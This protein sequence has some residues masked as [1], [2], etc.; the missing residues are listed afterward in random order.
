MRVRVPDMTH[1]FQSID[2][3]AECGQVAGDGS[4]KRRCSAIW[5][6]SRPG[7]G[8]CQLETGHDGPHRIR[9]WN[10]EI[11]LNDEGMDEIVV[12]EPQPI[13]IGLASERN[14]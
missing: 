1:W 5:T 11:T 10:G 8:F 6:S 13:P 2:T 14:D 4:H 3:C 7:Y 9:W 12:Q